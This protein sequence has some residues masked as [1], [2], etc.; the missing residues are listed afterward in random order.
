MKSEGRVSEDENVE[1]L[2]R[3]PCKRQSGRPGCT[4]FVK[5]ASRVPAKR[6]YK[7]PIFREMESEGRVSEDENLEG[8]FR[9]PCKR[10]SGRPGCNGFVKEPSHLPKKRGYKSPIF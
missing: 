5:E 9:R 6:E 4:G 7:S 2:F 10:Q 8:L 1:G 3:R